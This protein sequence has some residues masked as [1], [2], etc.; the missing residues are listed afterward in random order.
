MPSV[1]YEKQIEENN[2]DIILK[3]LSNEIILGK[4]MESTAME[5]DA[6]GGAS[7]EQ[8]QELIKKECDKRDKNYCSLEQKYNKLQES[9]EQ[10]Q[11][12]NSKTRG[13]GGASSKK[14][15]SP[16]T[17]R[18]AQSQRGQPTSKRRTQP[19]GSRQPNPQ[20][21]KADDTTNVISTEHGRN[22]MRRRRSRSQL[23]KK[24]SSTDR[25]KQ[26]LQSGTK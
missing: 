4:T 21:G 18:K 11:Q 1:S 16:T 15:L 9:L 13:Q 20:K 2:R 14:K 25:N 12:K 17:A 8:L 3:K 7:F 22:S 26:R 19:Q 5:R 6:E 10:S 24:T 23:K